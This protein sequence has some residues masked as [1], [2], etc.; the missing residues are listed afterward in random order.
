MIAETF[1]E[2][3]DA[4]GRQ[5]NRPFERRRGFHSTF[6]MGR[7]VSHPLAVKCTTI[8]DVRTFLTG[9]RSV[10]DEKLFGRRDYW[11][12]PDEFERRK[13]GDCEDFSLWTWRE[14]MEMGFTARFVA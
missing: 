3:Y 13:A 6:P 5:V 7:Y 1:P 9:C 10:S 4:N 11:E 2:A 14:F 12:P 8:S